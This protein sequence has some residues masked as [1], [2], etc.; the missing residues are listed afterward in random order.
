MTIIEG[1]VLKERMFGEQDKFIDVLTK[2]RG[3][4][5]LPVRGARKING[6][7]SSATQLFAYSRFCYEQ[8]KNRLVLNS[9]EPV[10]IFY[11]LRNS[12]SAISL[13]SYFADVVRSCIPELTDSENVARLL[14]N[15]LHYLEK[16]LRSE[17]MLKSIFELRLMSE[18]G[19]MP[20]VLA[21]RN[22]GNFE[23][24]ELYFSV[25]GEFFCT[26]CCESAGE[27]SFRMKLPVLSAIRHIVLSDFDRLFNFRVSENTLERLSA[28]SESYIISHLEKN[29]KTLD[30]YKSL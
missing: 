28:F 30:F 12:L 19:F 7:M 2:D 23:P 11:G 18:T 13:A 24:D 20:D 29:F 27:N 1:I 6:R 25:S 3:V 16:N 5:E 10:H 22:C 9:A 4:M 15:T 21:C 26:D 14:L 8:K 17:K